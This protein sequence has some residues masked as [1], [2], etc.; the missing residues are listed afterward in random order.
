M[1]PGRLPPHV[2]LL[3][4]SYPVSYSRFLYREAF[5]LSKAGYRVTLI[6]LEDAEPIPQDSQVKVVPVP[7]RRLGRKF[8]TVCQVARI[9]RKEQAQVYHCLDP[10]ALS[11][12]FSLKRTQPS[13]KVIYEA[14][15]WFSRAQFERQDLVLPVRR[16]AYRWI[17]GLE[18]RART[19]ADAIIDTN[20]TRAQRFSNASCPVVLV[21]NYPRREDLPAPA[22]QRNLYLAYTGLISRHRGFE[23][24]LRALA[25]VVHQHP[26]VK[27]CVVGNFDSRDNLGPWTSRF[28]NENGL[29]NNLELLG[30][31]PYHEMFKRIVPC[32]AGVILLQPGRT[33]DYTGQPNKLFEFMGTGLAVVCSDFPEM[34]SIVRLHRCG[35]LVDPTDVSAVAA[36]ISEAIANPA[37][38]VLRGQAAREAVLANYTWDVAE[39]RLLDLYQQILSS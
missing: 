25:V 20:P 21:P 4:A 29:P 33:N 23:V 14:T 11:I 5:S 6:G 15:E 28:V 38:T 27:L 10:W 8:E 31:L 3:S 22:E 16:L 9:A 26:E 32:L 2:C 7:V 17:E 19:S 37:A 30:W 12:G 34:A 35:W 18:R 24:L 36:A 13:A 1:N 39:E